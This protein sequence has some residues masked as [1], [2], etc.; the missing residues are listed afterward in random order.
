MTSTRPRRDHAPCTASTIL[1]RAKWNVTLASM[2]KLMVS[3]TVIRSL[4]ETIEKDFGAAHGAI[5]KLFL[6]N[7]PNGYSVEPEL[8]PHVKS[9]PRP[10]RVLR[11]DTERFATHMRHIL[12]DV[13]ANQ[14]IYAPFKE[15]WTAHM[16]K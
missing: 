3:A 9:G 2:D 16:L 4:D 12:T 7:R 8:E 14:A 13:A 11:L 6:D 1:L 5:I 15:N 10:E